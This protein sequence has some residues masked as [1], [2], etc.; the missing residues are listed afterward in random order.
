VKRRV[1]GVYHRLVSIDTRLS[2]REW[3]GL[4]GALLPIPLVSVVLWA[5]HGMGPTDREIYALLDHRRPAVEQRT[6]E[7]FQGCGISVR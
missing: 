3:V 2:A 4:L 7:V 1:N 6:I 5:M